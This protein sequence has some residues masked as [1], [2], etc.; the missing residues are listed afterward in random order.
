MSLPPVVRLP[1]LYAVCRLAPD[2]PLPVWFSV[3]PPPTDPEVQQTGDLLG[4]IRTRDE[5]TLV[6]PQS[7]V[8]GDIV[9]QRGWSAFQLVGPLELHQTGILAELSRRM[10]EAQIPIF[11]ISTY[12]TDY[13]LVPQAHATTAHARMNERAAD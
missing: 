10:A 6:C 12:D 8:P 4:L 9:A 7:Q 2:A 1:E 11:V 5:L 13:I 3:A